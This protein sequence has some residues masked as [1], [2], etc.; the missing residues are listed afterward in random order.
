MYEMKKR[1]VYLNKTI[2]FLQPSGGCSEVNRL[3]PP[4]VFLGIPN[5]LKD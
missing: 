4:F 3:H 1:G 2:S 5:R